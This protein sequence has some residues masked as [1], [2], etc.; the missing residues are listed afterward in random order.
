MSFDVITGAARVSGYLVGFHDRAGVELLAW[1][2][3]P[4]AAAAGPDYPHLHVSAALR[5]LLP[6]GDRAIVPL[7]KLHLPTGVVPLTAVVRMLIEEFGVQP[8]AADWRARLAGGG[9]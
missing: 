4:D 7:D 6:S 2:W 8:R 1:H 3:Q 5:P 9:V